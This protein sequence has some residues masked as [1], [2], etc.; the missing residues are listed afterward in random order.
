MPSLRKARAIRPGAVVGIAAN[1]RD[2][3][4]ESR[5]TLFLPMRASEYEG[6]LT[7][8]ARTAGPPAPVVRPFIEAAQRKH[9]M[10]DAD[11]MC[12][13]RGATRSARQIAPHKSVCFPNA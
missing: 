6:G 10:P 1:N 13:R 4:R 5:P 2:H 12:G 3:G 11:R 8:I 9:G 7:V